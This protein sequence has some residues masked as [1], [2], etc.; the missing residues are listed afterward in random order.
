MYILNYLI[1][2]FV[3][4][5]LLGYVNGIEKYIINILDVIVFMYNYYFLWGGRVWSEFY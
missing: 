2:L 1:L 4:D 5:F 3:D